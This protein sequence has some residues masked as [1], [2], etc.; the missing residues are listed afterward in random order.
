[1]K[2]PKAEFKKIA[3]AIILIVSFGFI[4]W[5][6]VLA[7]LGTYTVN[8]SIAT[9]FIYTVIGAYASYCLASYGEKN[10]RNKY[11]IDENGNKR[12]EKGGEKG[13]D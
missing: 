7:S 12:A 3:F 2:K 11:D 9:A 8:E 6:Y 10:S 13:D 5:T 4:L 1:M